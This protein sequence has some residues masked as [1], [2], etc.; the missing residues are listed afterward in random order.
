MGAACVLSVG[1]LAMA[2]A[3]RGSCFDLRD[4]GG[5]RLLRRPELISFYGEFPD[6]LSLE[7][8]QVVADIGGKT[9]W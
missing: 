8:E 2:A 7:G 4:G 1:L 6:I 5:L 3:K 9:A